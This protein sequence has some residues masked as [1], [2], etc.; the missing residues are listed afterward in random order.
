MRLVFVTKETLGEWFEP[1]RHFIRQ[2]A[3]GS[4]GRHTVG[5]LR[6]ELA[7]GN[8]WLVLAVEDPAVRAALIATSATWSTGLRELVIV[9][10]TGSGMKDWLHLEGEIRK[11]AKATGHHVAKAVARPGY[12]RV[13]KDR[14]YKMT[15]VILETPL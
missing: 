2:I 9:G 12:A 15:H 7:H 3:E 6:H 13:L 4:G 8:Y 10:L 5:S 14:G 11:T 1:A